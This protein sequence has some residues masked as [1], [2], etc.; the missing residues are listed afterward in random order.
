MRASVASD[1][2]LRKHLVLVEDIL[3]T[4][5]RID[6]AECHSFRETIDLFQTYDSSL[7]QIV[8]NLV[9]KKSLVCLPLI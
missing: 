3:Q 9:Q 8:S 7:D 4:S 6:T 5:N 2:R 1:S